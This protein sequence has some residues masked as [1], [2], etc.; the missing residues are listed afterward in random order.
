[1]HIFFLSLYNKLLG[2]HVPVFAR[3]RHTGT[4]PRARQ[5]GRTTVC[6]LLTSTDAFMFSVIKIIFYSFSAIIMTVHVP[7]LQF[8]RFTFKTPTDSSNISGN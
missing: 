8:K 6:C 5:A 7:K 3:H 4:E 2:V 1:M